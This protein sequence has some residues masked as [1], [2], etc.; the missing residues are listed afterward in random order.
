MCIRDSFHRGNEEMPMPSDSRPS[1]AVAVPA[2]PVPAIVQP[3]TSLATEVQF[4]QGL[5]QAL[6]SVLERRYLSNFRP[7]D[8]TIQPR[9]GD[10][11]CPVLRE[12][13]SYTHLRA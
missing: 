12:A 5:P 8:W 13:V 1:R 6:V 4:T 11:A 10:N 7:V 3:E 2:A 9:P